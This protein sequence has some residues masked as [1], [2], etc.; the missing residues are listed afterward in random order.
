MNQPI[1]SRWPLEARILVWLCLVLI[2][3]G[4]LGGATWLFWA[5]S[6]HPNIVVPEQREQRELYERYTRIEF[7]HLCYAEEQGYEAKQG[8]A[9]TQKNMDALVEESQ[10]RWGVHPTAFANL[11]RIG[12]GYYGER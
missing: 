3:G 1:P 2:G 6:V 5:F 7:T 12:S 4:V 9:E 10:R 11:P 8:A